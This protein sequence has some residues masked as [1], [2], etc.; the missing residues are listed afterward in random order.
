MY[1]DNMKFTESHE[2][3]IENS[4]GSANIGVTKHAQDLLGD[5]VYIE[6]PKVGQLI[7]AKEA[8]GVIESVKAASDLYAP[9]T[10]VVLC[11]NDMVINDPTIINND[12]HNNGWM[13]KITPS[14]NS[15]LN[16]LMNLDQYQQ[17]IK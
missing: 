12:P 2:W 9:I 16:D 14:N 5:I 13:I 6:L 7:R 11:I 3:V 15:E 17:M 1:K 10:G 4:D 8:M